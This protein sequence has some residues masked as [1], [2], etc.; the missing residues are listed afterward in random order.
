MQAKTNSWTRSLRQV[1]RS[2]WIAVVAVGGLVVLYGAV[3]SVANQ[4]LAR[5]LPGTIAQFVGG[6]DAARY[7]VSVGSVRLTPDLRGVTVND[8]R[9]SLRPAASGEIA[10]P[11]LVRAANLGSLRVVGLRLMP[12]LRGQGIFVTSI[13][14]DGPRFELDFTAAASADTTVS[15]EIDTSEPSSTS[16]ASLP[17]T[18]GLEQLTIRDGSIDITRLTERGV[19]GSF[20]HGLELELTDIRVDTVTLANPARALANSS[21]TVAF[22][23]VF[24]VM[25]DS[26]YSLAITGVRADSRDSVVEVGRVELIP[27]L[28]AG[29]F[30]ARQTQRAD[31][32]TIRAGP[33]RVGGLDF[34]D[35]VREDSVA[36]RI[37]EV[38]SL[39]L[40]SYSDIKLDWGP[41]ARPCRYH[42]DFESIPVPFR[43]D[44]IRV[45]D[46]FI[47][48][49]ELAK[50]S[51][52]PG[53]LTLE[54]MNGVITNL[55]NDPGRMT[56][57]TPL[58]V[59]ATAK[60]FG[61]GR[62]N[63]KLSYPL[64]SKTL[65][66]DIEA[67]LG[68]MGLQVANRFATN[69]A[70]VDV[71]QGR[72]DSLWIGTRTR[73]GKAQGRVYMRYRDLDFRL[74]DRNTGEQQ[75]QHSVLGFVGNLVVRKNNPAK[76]GDK[77]KDGTIDYTCG[78]DDI[79]FFEFFVHS[80]ANGL[81]RIVL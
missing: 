49:S 20:L 5:L 11:A 48:Y 30:F 13:D 67:S 28:E 55:T 80:L 44:S 25:D 31:R 52:R 17:P 62:M 47:R 56:R 1:P 42:M 68:P 58:V 15:T 37:I 43:I 36:V 61:S 27:T 39:D 24:H 4:Q 38:D 77:P 75:V 74:I 57:E 70:G 81:K 7:E 16:S 50:G 73:S 54:E 12:L 41:R 46:A 33:I 65:D 6:H 59:E 66:F 51:V 45:N 14:I 18:A 29:P 21:V 3:Y 69:V 63:A 35:Y 76:P 53:E 19:L 10:E 22:D 2:A 9:V 79:A 23:S 60:L 71:K 8:L 32:L 72:L 26:L 64:L 78:K 40:H 34:A